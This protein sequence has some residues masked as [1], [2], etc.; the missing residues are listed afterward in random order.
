MRPGQYVP[1]SEDCYSCHS[2]H[3][4]VDTTFVQFYPTLL[5]IASAKGALGSGYLKDRDALA[6]KP[7]Q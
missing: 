4:A 2:E 7:A 3:G 5:Q 6:S 1:T